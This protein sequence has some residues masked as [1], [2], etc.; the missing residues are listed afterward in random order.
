MIYSTC[1]VLYLQLW[2]LASHLQLQTSACPTSSLSVALSA[3]L[4]HSQVQVVVVFFPTSSSGNQ[5][6]AMP[7]WEVIPLPN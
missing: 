1:N 5:L 3:H 7:Q 4:H 2:S 6:F